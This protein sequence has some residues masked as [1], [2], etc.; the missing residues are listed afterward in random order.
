MIA[1]AGATDP[2]GEPSEPPKS[3][4]A[5]AAPSGRWNPDHSLGAE[6]HHL[7]YVKRRVAHG[8]MSADVERWALDAL[9]RPVA[10]LFGHAF[11]ADRLEAP[12]RH[13]LWFVG[14]LRDSRTI[15]PLG[16]DARLTVRH[17]IRSTDH[18]EDGYLSACVQRRRLKDQNV[19]VFAAVA[20]PAC[21]EYFGFNNL[22][23]ILA[24]ALLPA[25]GLDLTPAAL[26][27]ALGMRLQSPRRLPDGSDLLSRLIDHAAMLSRRQQIF[28]SYRWR[29]ATPFVARLARRLDGA[30]YTCWWDRWSMSRAVA[31]GQA[32]SPP[33]ALRGVLEH[34]IARCAGVSRFAPTD[35]TTATGP[36]LSTTACSTR[37]GRGQWPSS[38]CRWLRMA[39]C[40]CQSPNAAIW[41]PPM[42]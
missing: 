10:H 39:C 42:H 27:A 2:T 40:Q 7:V 15:L 23:P 12:G 18:L 17:V 5:M 26:T 9:N 4:R 34:A 32:A 8:P 33:P 24:P 36:V 31:E 37:I 19:A 25:K 21:S 30:G 1:T 35:M 29:E 11:L 16:L 20:D 14:G 22:E 13:M 28:I 6:T 3:R 38:I 41:P